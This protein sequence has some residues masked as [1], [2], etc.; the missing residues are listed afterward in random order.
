MGGPHDREHPQAEP[1]NLPSW[2]A[3]SERAPHPWLCVLTTRQNKQ[4]T[5]LIHFQSFDEDYADFETKIQDLDRRLATIFCQAFDDC[6][7]IESGAK[8]GVGWGLQAASRPPG[9]TQGGPG[10]AAVVG[11]GLRWVRWLP[12]RVR[13]GI[14]GKGTVASLLLT[15]MGVPSFSLIAP[16]LEG[17][18]GQRH[19]CHENTAR[20]LSDLLSHTCTRFDT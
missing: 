7:S 9:A 20:T 3:R 18:K 2:G 19:G 5:V 17:T 4:T 8:V 10:G 1:R 13:K 15:R 14:E 12:R 11:G 6:S 16:L